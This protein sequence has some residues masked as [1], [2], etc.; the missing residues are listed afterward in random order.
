M[1]FKA[2]PPPQKPKPPAKPPS[3]ISN[4]VLNTVR[5]GD[6]I[7]ANHHRKGEF[8]SDELCSIFN[9][10][11]LIFARMTAGVITLVDQNGA[12]RYSILHIT[13]L[14]DV[15]K[16]D[17]LSPSDK[18]AVARTLIAKEDYKKK[19]TE[20]EVIKRNLIPAGEVEVHIASAFKVL[21]RWLD[22]LPD[23]VEK[24]ALIDVQ[25]LIKFVALINRAKE[26]LL[27]DLSNI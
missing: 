14:N 8:T 11:P 21:S 25:K 17:S 19:K 3:K 20:N 13:K 18:L 4:Q 12:T 9:V 10:T 7:R 16:D 23:L 24:K 5:A 6:V 1:T 26:Q 27:I 22:L 15:R 2:P